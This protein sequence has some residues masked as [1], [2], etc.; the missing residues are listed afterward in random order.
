MW[1]PLGDRVLVRLDQP[2]ERVSAG[3]VVLPGQ[4]EESTNK[5]AAVVAVGRD[6]KELAEGDRVVMSGYAGTTAEGDEGAR[7]IR[8]SDVVV[9]LNG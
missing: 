2:E 5:H 7:I 4:A 3:G 6:V 1:R 9:V 8:E